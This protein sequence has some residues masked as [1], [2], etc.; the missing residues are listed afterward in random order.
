MAEE[1]KTLFEQQIELVKQMP[2]GSDKEQAINQL[3]QDYQGMEEIITLELETAD[4]NID[5]PSPQGRM[6]GDVYTAPDPTEHIGAALREGIGQYGRKR[7]LDEKRDLS[8]D[9]TAGLT[10]MVKGAFQGQQPP[11]P[12]NV[13][14]GAQP[15]PATNKLLRQPPQA[16]GQP[17]PAMPAPAASPQAGAIPPEQLAEALRRKEEEEMRRGY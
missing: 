17:S 9:R 15:Q 14:R 7:A 4:Q 10:S 6:T 13:P 12:Q 11:P 8:A 3:F 16:M 2:E 1:E 5:T